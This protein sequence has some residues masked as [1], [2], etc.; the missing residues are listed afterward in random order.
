M[1]FLVHEGSYSSAPAS[2]FQLDH[3]GDKKNKG[4][5]LKFGVGGKIKLEIVEQTV[6]S[7]VRLIK[8]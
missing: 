1:Q 3:F 2:L 4:Y 7:L 5:V 6:P 8:A